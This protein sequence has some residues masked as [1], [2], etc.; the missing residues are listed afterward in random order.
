MDQILNKPIGRFPD[1]AEYSAVD[2]IVVCS[3]VSNLI[4]VYKVRLTLNTEPLHDS[5]IKP[6]GRLIEMF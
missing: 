6:A 2:N 5:S 4:S 1:G 3:I